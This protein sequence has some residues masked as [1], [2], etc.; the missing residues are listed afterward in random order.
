MFDSRRTRISGWMR[1]IG[2]RR[3]GSVTSTAP[4]GWL[5]WRRSPS[6]MSLFSVFTSWPNSRGNRR[7]VPSVFISGYGRTCSSEFVVA[8]SLI[9]VGGA[10]G[11]KQRVAD[12]RAIGCGIGHVPSGERGLRLRRHLSKWLTASRLSA[13]ILRSRGDPGGFEAAH[14]LQ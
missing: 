9:G 1:P 10:A 4:A 2:S 3:P 7:S 5:E 14:H 6:L 8:L 12:N 11:A 13:S